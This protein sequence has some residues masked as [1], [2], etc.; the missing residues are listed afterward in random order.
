VIVG[1]KLTASNSGIVASRFSGGIIAAV[2]TLPAFFDFTNNGQPLTALTTILNALNATYTRNSV[3]NVVQNGALVSLS[4]NQFGTSYDTVEGTYGYV[5]EPAA[6]NLATN[7]DGAAAT[8]TCSNTADGTAVTGF[9]NGISFGDNS[10]QRSA[11]KSISTTSG[12]TYTISVFVIMGDA[13]A[14]VVGITNSTGDFGL[15]VDSRLINTATTLVSQLGGGSNVYRVSGSLAATSTATQSY[16]VVKY[17][18]QSA[19]TFRITGIQ[20]ETGLRAT[21]YI[22]TAGSTASRSADALTVPLWINNLKDSQDF[23]TANWSRTNCTVTTSGTA[24]DGSATAQL[25]TVTTTASAQVNS[26]LFKAP[27]STVT[28]SQYVKQGNK[29]TAWLVLRNATTSTNFTV[30]TLTFATG[31]V[32]GTG[33]AATDVG[34]GWFRCTYTNKPGDVISVGDSLAVYPLSSASRTAGDTQYAWGFQLEPGSVATT[35]RQTT[36]TLESDANANIKGFSSA[37][38]TLVSD[39]RSDVLTSAT[40]GLIEVGDNSST[41]RSGLGVTVAG[42]LTYYSNTGGSSQVNVSGGNFATSRG[43][44]S[45]SFKADSF[46]A[47]ASGSGLTEDT[48]GTMPSGSF[49]LLIGNVFTGGGQFNGFIFGEK[50]ITMPTTQAQLNGLTQ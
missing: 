49:I 2:G 40:R 17:T 18:G 19:R 47:A 43:K 26:A 13:S 21:S 32:T 5:P 3:K 35:Y 7:S 48:S 8:Y 44:A 20:V 41:N 50:L 30:G 4:A 45:G 9:T 29:P 39:F 24:P 12:T 23:S 42:G 10:V 15:V 11:Y 27:A 37:G 46:K 16:G 25:I 38:Y 36:S 6:T 33:W 28:V 22:A 1:K 34:N 14:P 31:V